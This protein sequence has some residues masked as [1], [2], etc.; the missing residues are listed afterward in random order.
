MFQPFQMKRSKFKNVLMSSL[1]TGLKLPSLGKKL[2]LDIKMQSLI[3]NS[4]LKI[5]SKL[6]RIKKIVKF[7]LIHPLLL[8]PFLKTDREEANL[9]LML[10]LMALVWSSIM[11]AILL[12]LFR[13][14]VALSE[15]R[16]R[17]SGK[18]ESVLFLLLRCF[19]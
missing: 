15:D 11:N 2:A 17:I 6:A 16:S 7:A 8:K 3:K 5:N 12:L 1:S 19:Q 13:E 9:T 10:L 14:E 4:H 18:K